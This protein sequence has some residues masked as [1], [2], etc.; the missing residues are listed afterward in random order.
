MRENLRRSRLLPLLNP[1]NCLES[2]ARSLR[3]NR[4]TATSA[5]LKALVLFSDVPFLPEKMETHKKQ[6]VVEGGQP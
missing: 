1:F 3:R 4:L 6:R 5:A 2:A